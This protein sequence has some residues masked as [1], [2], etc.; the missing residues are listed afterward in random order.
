[1]PASRLLDLVSSCLA[2]PMQGDATQAQSDAGLQVGGGGVDKRLFS[3]KSDDDVQVLGEGDLQRLATN[4][5]VNKQ[6]F[7]KRPFLV[8]E[9]APEAVKEEA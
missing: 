1:M 8:E 3:Q 9:D 4:P 6:K 5:F 2:I 7:G